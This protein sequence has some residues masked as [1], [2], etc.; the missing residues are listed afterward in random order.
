MLEVESRL[1]ILPKCGMS[2]RLYPAP[3]TGWNHAWLQVPSW[4]MKGLLGCRAPADHCSRQSLRA[5]RGVCSGEKCR[6]HH[7][8][9]TAPT[10]HV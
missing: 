8:A 9:D 10:E 1:E 5:E 2:H 7:G 4:C 3:D 6:T